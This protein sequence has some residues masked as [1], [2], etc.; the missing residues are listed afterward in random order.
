M[1]SIQS[2]KVY[3]CSVCK[4]DKPLSEMISASLIRES[5]FNLIADEIPGWGADDYRDL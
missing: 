4:Q 1:S 3:H 2:T 5:I